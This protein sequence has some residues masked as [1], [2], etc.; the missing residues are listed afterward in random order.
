MKALFIVL[1]LM[2]CTCSDQT[3]LQEV[4]EPLPTKNVDF[5]IDPNDQP[6]WLLEVFGKAMALWATHGVD[7]GFDEEGKIVIIAY[8]PE[9]WIDHAWRDFDDGKWYIQIAQDPR[10]NLTC[11]AAKDIG[12]G[13]GLGLT[14]TGLLSIESLVGPDEPC[15]WS[16]E[17]Y[18]Q[19]CLNFDHCP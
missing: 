19:V 7:L 1:G 4:P 12:Y 5:L 16:Q 14:R 15:P 2:L 17:D 10:F 3:Y 13:I 11:L 9:G 6:P 8:A 18:W